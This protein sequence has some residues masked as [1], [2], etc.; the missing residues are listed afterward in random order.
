MSKR[1]PSSPPLEPPPER[2]TSALLEYYW[3]S[4]CDFR[5]FSFLIDTVL[6][7]DFVAHIASQALDGK[8]KDDSISPAD[9]ARTNPGSRTKVLRQS[10]QELI[11]MFYSRA[12]DNFQIYVVEII[13]AVL[14]KKPQILS[15]RRQELTLGYILQFDSIEA[16]AH[17][18]VEGKVNSLSYEG[19]GELEA[20][21]QSKGIPLVVPDGRRDDV[22]E[23]IATRN[24]IVHNRGVV[25]SRYLKA[26]AGSKFKVGEK[27]TLEVDDLFHSMDLLNR[28]VS[29]SDASISGKFDLAREN[30]R[31][32]LNRRAKDR[33]PSPEKSGAGAAAVVQRTSRRQMLPKPE[34]RGSGGAT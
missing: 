23:L 24:L 19:F 18:I 8:G 7:G 13:R 29:V 17:D 22:V 34:P 5:L 9:L 30:I 16:L 4:S 15:A 20:W 10:R 14:R 25:D 11:E 31:R 26:V 2:G 28:V 27:R 21:C 1:P 33:W 6:T 32:A 12:V 3:A